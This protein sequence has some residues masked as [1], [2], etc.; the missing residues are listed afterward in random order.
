MI[1]SLHILDSGFIYNLIF[2]TILVIVS[3]FF[4]QNIIAGKS[5]QLVSM[6][7]GSALVITIL[8]RPINGLIILPFVSYLIPYEL[9]VTGSSIFSPG[10]LISVITLFATFVH[11]SFG[12]LRPNISWIWLVI[13][14]F[15]FLF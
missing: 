13:K 3:Q 11:I 9:Q 14:S 1:R 15:C 6:M 2:I 4:A 10:F 7:F 8:K 12:K 5:L